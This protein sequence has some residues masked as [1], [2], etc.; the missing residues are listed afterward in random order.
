MI[1]VWRTTDGLLFRYTTP[2]VAPI[3]LIFNRHL[4]TRWCFPDH[5]TQ[6]QASHLSWDQCQTTVI[7]WPNT[8]DT[9]ATNMSGI[10]CSC[11]CSGV[12]G[13]QGMWHVNRH[14]MKPA[15]G[16]QSDP[17]C[18]ISILQIESKEIILILPSVHKT[19]REFSD[20]GPDLLCEIVL[21]TIHSS[22]G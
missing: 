21:L 11:L 15:C 1:I 22:L 20:R 19:V 18:E 14:G 12:H 8:V 13:T 2:H 10:V 16:S 9:T 3:W 6:Q 5:V 17:R 7:T 4:D